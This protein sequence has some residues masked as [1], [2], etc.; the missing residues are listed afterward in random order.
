[1]KPNISKELYEKAGAMVRAMDSTYAKN[2]AVCK[3]IKA[4]ELRIGEEFDEMETYCL[5]V[6]ALMIVLL[7]SCVVLNIIIWLMLAHFC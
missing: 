7:V 3:D 6:T 1:M 2:E 5:R 4:A